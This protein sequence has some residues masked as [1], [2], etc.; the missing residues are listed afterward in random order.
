MTSRE[1]CSYTPEK[2]KHSTLR[3]LTPSLRS[4]Q[5]TVMKFQLASDSRVYFLASW[6]RLGR[7]SVIA[8]SYRQQPSHSVSVGRNRVRCI[9]GWTDQNVVWSVDL[10]GP[11]KPPIWHGAN[12]PGPSLWHVQWSIY[13]HLTLKGVPCGLLVTMT[14][15]TKSIAITLDFDLFKSNVDG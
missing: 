8:A 10:R 7:I 9:N 4:I 5:F 6:E 2:N 14:V 1:W 15:A 3:V 11:Y 12:P 13:T